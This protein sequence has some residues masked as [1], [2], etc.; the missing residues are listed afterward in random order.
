MYNCITPESCND[1]QFFCVCRKLSQDV[2][3]SHWLMQ[4]RPSL[5]ATFCLASFKVKGATVGLSLFENRKLTGG[6][7]TIASPQKVATTCGFFCVLTSVPWC[8]WCNDTFLRLQHSVWQEAL[9]K[10]PTLDRPISMTVYCNTQR[11]QWHWFSNTHR[12]QQHRCNSTSPVST[13][14]V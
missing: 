10:K 8:S 14:P 13:T 7:I 12:C 11:C 4:W 2:A 9:E 5:T 6:T 3:I 1:Q